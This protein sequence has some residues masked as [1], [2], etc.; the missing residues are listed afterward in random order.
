MTSPALD[1]QTRRGPLPHP[2][3]APGWSGPRA[4]SAGL[5]A[6]VLIARSRKTSVASRPPATGECERKAAAGLSKRDHARCSTRCASVRRLS[7]GSDRKR[8]A[9]GA[10]GETVPARTK[11]A[12]IATSVLGTNRLL[13][14]RGA[15]CTLPDMYGLPP[16]CRV[17]EAS[18]CR[19][20]SRRRP[21][22]LPGT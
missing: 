12:A 6:P 3:D 11:T 21:E 10:F 13:H 2:W 15:E 20:T 22:E 9:A 4:R 7:S 14:D 5:N 17:S 1:I 16:P 19:R 8:C 18:C